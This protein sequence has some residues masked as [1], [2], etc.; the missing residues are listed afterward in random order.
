MEEL[1]SSYFPPASNPPISPNFSSS[2][3]VKLQTAEG[4]LSVG[5]GEEGECA[6]AGEKAG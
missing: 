4:C 2:E 5:G 3:P 6:G 1:C